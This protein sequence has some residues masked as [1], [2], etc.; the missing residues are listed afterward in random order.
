MYCMLCGSRLSP[1]EKRGNVPS[2]ASTPGVPAFATEQRRPRP[3]GRRPRSG[4]RSIR[5]AF[6][7]RV[8]L[9]FDS[10]RPACGAEGAEQ[11]ESSQTKATPN[12]RVSPKLRSAG[13]ADKPSKPN[14]AGAGST[15]AD[16]QPARRIVAVFEQ[17]DAVVDADTE[18]HSCASTANSCS[19]SPSSPA[20]RAS[21]ARRAASAARRATPNCGSA[22]RA[23]ARPPRSPAAAASSSSR[24]TA[25]AA[26]RFS[27]FDRS[28]VRRRGRWQRRAAHRD[29]KSSHRRPSRCCRGDRRF[30]PAQRQ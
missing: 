23:R 5:C 4:P 13:V 24:D 30:A 7:F 21:A 27:R 17:E 10:C 12:S 9:R 25:A 16:R 26:S 29:R 8:F 11:G 28:S 22:A 3:R 14:A 18:Q 6:P 2:P 15:D 1:I 19:G 20:R